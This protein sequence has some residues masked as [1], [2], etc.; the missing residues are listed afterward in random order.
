MKSLSR[1]LLAWLVPPLFVVGVVAASGAYVFM[2]R[3]LTAAYDQDLGDIARALVPYLRD[4]DGN[5]LLAFSDQADA[6][7]RADSRDQIF[8]AVKDDAGRLIAGDPALPSPPPFSD[9]MPLFWNDVRQGERIRAV[10]LV[11]YIA[12]TPVIVVAAE[13]MNK[14]D[15]ASRDAMFSAISP[16]ALLSIAAVAA[17]FFGVRRGLGPVE[18]L[19]EQ[20]LSRSHVD[21]GPVDEGNAAEELKPLVHALNDMLGR[22][23]SAQSSQARF[24]ANAAHQLRTPIAGLVTQ[25]DLARTGGPEGQTHLEHA[26]AAAA[27]LARLAQQI[28][29]L[30]AAD[31]ISNPAPSREDCDL[32]AIV[33]EHAGEWLRA[34]PDVEMEFDLQSAPVHGN[35][36]LIGE[37]ASNLVDNAARYGARNVKVATSSRGAHAILEVEDDGPGIPPQERTRIFERFHRLA[38]APSDGSGLGLAI[39]AEIAQQHEASVNVEDARG[40]GTGTR[41]VVSFPAAR[42]SL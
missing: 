25:I 42:H 34:R 20:L 4:K 40:G 18:R 16:V 12:G 37:L 8:Y 21:L 1:T 30:A 28:L 26:R 31:P 10:A 22:L 19:R 41:V 5:V 17:L 32:A 6:V 7:L 27:R 36:L 14:R 24:I 15:S 13:T 33:T 9:D 35:A 3:R 11:S 29:S 2:E 39:V 23:N 38:A